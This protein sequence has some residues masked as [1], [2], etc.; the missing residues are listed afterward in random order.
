MKKKY[1]DLLTDEQRP[2]GD[3]TIDT[4]KGSG[5]KAC[6]P[7]IPRPVDADGRTGSTGSR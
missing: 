5:Q 1:I 6:R 7:R 2:V 3:D 4:L